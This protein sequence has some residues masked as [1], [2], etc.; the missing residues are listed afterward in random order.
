MAYGKG[1]ME[2]PWDSYVKTIN[3]VFVVCGLCQVF[4]VWR[5]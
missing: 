2:R 1:L 5:R 3:I 4:D